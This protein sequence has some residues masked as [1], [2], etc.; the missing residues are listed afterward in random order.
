MRRLGPVVA[1]LALAACGEKIVLETLE[2]GETFAGKRGLIIESKTD[3]PAGG[4][5][6]VRGQACIITGKKGTLTIY[7]FV[8][9]DAGASYINVNKDK[10]RN[11]VHLQYGKVVFA[12]EGKTFGE[13]QEILVLLQ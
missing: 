11:I 12:I 13:R 8:S 2:A 5:A 4:G 3:V 1:L 9:K 6:I 10:N 7:Q